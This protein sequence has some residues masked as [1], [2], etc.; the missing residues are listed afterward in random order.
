MKLSKVEPLFEGK[1]STGILPDE[2]N[3]RK[4][5]SV[6]N[7]T[8][9]IVNIWKCN[10]FIA[11]IV[12]DENIGKMVSELM[13]WSGCRVAQD[14]LFWKPQ[15]GGS[16][17]YHQ[18][19]P[20]MDFIP[21]ETVAV[22]VPLNDVS[23]ENGT[24]EYA[25]GSH[26]WKT[27]SGVID[28]FH[29]PMKFKLKMEDAARIE[30]IE[31]PDIHHVTLK[32]GGV[33]LHD[34]ML[35]HG[36]SKN[37][38]TTKERCAFAFHFIPENCVFKENPGYIYGRYKF[39]DNNRVDESFFPITYSSIEEFQPQEY[40]YY[41]KYSNGTF[42]N[43][44]LIFSFE[45]GAK[46]SSDFLSGTVL[47]SDSY[48]VIKSSGQLNVGSI[49][50]NISV[51]LGSL[52][53]VYSVNLTCALIDLSTIS[54]EID[55]IK[56][57]DRLGYYSTITIHGM[58]Y[59]RF[60]ILETSNDSLASIGNS[61]N[62]IRIWSSSIF[63]NKMN[64]TF[65]IQVY[66]SRKV[67]FLQTKS[68]YYN[69]P[70]PSLDSQYIE[71]IPNYI[72]NSSLSFTDFGYYY[73]PLFY[74]IS[75][76][77]TSVPYQIYSSN[78][79]PFKTKLILGNKNKIKSIGSFKFY[80]GVSSFEIFFLKEDSSSFR[81]TLNMNITKFPS[82]FLGQIQ[83]SLIYSS[84]L[85]FISF[86]SNSSYNFFDCKYSINSY[87]FIS[88]WPF[89]FISGNNNNFKHFS[90][91][92]NPLYLSQSTLGI[93]ANIGDNLPLAFSTSLATAPIPDD[94]KPILLNYS[95]TRLRGRNS[96]FLITLNIES[97][98]GIQAIE[99]NQIAFGLETLVSGTNKNGTYEI[100]FQLSDS[101]YNIKNIKGIDIYSNFFFYNNNDAIRYHP[102]FIFK[103]PD[104]LINS[105]KT[106]SFNNISFAKNNLN[107]LNSAGYNT[108]YLNSST[109]DP[110]ALLVLILTDPISSSYQTI[111]DSLFYGSFPIVYD[112]NL[113][114]FTCDFIIP[115][116]NLFG[117]LTYFISHINGFITSNQLG[118]NS[119]KIIIDD[120]TYLD[121][122]GPL[123]NSFLKVNE[124]VI[125]YD[126]A[127]I[128]W[129]FNITDDF[130]GFSS[131]IITVRGSLDSSKYVFKFTLADAIAGNKLN[132]QYQILIPLSKQCISQN[133]IITNVILRDTNNISSVYN[134][135]SFEIPDSTITPF[136]NIYQYG[137]EYIQL[138]VTCQTGIVDQTTPTLLSFKH[139][140]TNSMADV[141]KID[142]SITFDFSIATPP[143]GIKQKQSPIVYILAKN[144]KSI[145][146]ISELVVIDN[147]YG[148]TNFTCTTTLPIGFGYPDILL[149]SIYGFIN[150]AGYY[151]GYSTFDLLS[152]FPSSYYVNTTFSVNDEPIIKST[153]N[154][155]STGGSLMIYG[156]SLS[157]T[158]H[159]SIYYSETG[160]QSTLIQD[161]IYGSSAVLINSIAET[162]KPFKIQITA[163]SGLKSNEYWVNPIYFESPTTPVIPTNPPQKCSGTPECGGKSQGYCSPNGCICYSP[164]I[165]VS[166]QSKVIVVP[167]PEVNPNEP[168]T[169][170]IT[171]STKSE[172]SSLV[173]VISIISLREL[174]VNNKVIK[175]FKF[176]KWNQT[177]LEKNKNIYSTSIKF[178]DGNN[179][180]C[181]INVETQWYEE[182]TNITFANQLLVM[183]PSTLKYNINITAYPFQSKL[184]TLQLVIRAKL[185]QNDYDDDVC[186]NQE[187]GNTVAD[188]SDFIQLS[189][190]D[191][192]LYGRFVKRGIVDGRILSIGNVKLED[193][194]DESNYYT[195][196]SF[197]GIAIPQYTSLVQLDP[198]FG[199]L[200]DSSPTDSMCKKG[201]SLSKGAMI[202]IIVGCVGF[203]IVVVIVVGLLVKYK[204]HLRNIKSVI[205]M[206]QLKNN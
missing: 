151:F 198:D 184:N 5:L 116:N 190:K 88:G 120:E 35:W 158:K 46:Y 163:T 161:A 110:D 169:N 27:S 178:G 135:Y 60:E 157:N 162:S 125:I 61:N 136:I 73:S 206:D 133:Y 195:S 113:K 64:D 44:N 75:D 181:F 145:E 98:N 9:E 159:V 131:G 179:N 185:I 104:Y 14:E 43:F 118:Y 170:I 202:G 121:N 8:R 32:R 107:L 147:I 4:G 154:I 6:E 16:V 191:H 177:N 68:F 112:S 76:T 84:Q 42:C 55:R 123:F 81:Q 160:A 203:V 139:S 183:N 192:S 22:W 19:G 117:E 102:L 3:Y 99:F 28:D 155:F 205:K 189:V 109:I 176:D 47:Y 85:F 17:G 111:E 58:D 204:Y 140:L 152:S 175:T 70:P 40:L 100:I 86:P 71:V 127:S 186:S 51:E 96:K 1:F 15:S 171:N 128:G 194:D 83:V 66:I 146:C 196:D 31:K 41:P 149:F 52:T 124:N 134:I 37:S 11:K 69:V 142:S 50:S 78:N 63:E 36:S 148:S 34:G 26:K 87:N 25:I 10:P 90:V 105:Y 143:T 12:F 197:I 48:Y 129:I 97:K 201:R 173:G 65:S 7:S 74:Y 106:N 167:Q 187:F 199:L 82:T 188:N 38:S 150:N 164:W 49:I 108:M 93:G 95:F 57:E 156:R 138:S 144:L 92:K 94:T 72:V 172:T 45:K 20:Y 174:D 13:G 29:N 24:L 80:Y 165:G 23:I 54:L 115:S 33:A 200:V 18:D 153:D 132:S 137:M 166:C 39:F 119:P 67:F 30:G 180:D 2:W 77:H 126:N 103:I 193:L 101:A 114:I 62:Y 182:L 21:F 89:G 59:H 79:F 56:Y 141:S 130:N 168:S 122:Q 53:S 91:F